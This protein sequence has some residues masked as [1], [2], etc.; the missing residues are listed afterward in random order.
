MTSAH[1]LEQW[2]DGPGAGEKGEPPELGRD[3]PGVRL[4]AIR[5]EDVVHAKERSAFASELE[6]GVIKH[7]NLTGGRP[8]HCAGELVRLEADLVALN[9][10]SGRYGP[11]SSEEMTA[12][13]KAF[14][15][16]GYGVWSYGYD[17]E[18]DFPFR[19]GSRLPEWVE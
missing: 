1:G 6:T 14:R 3:A 16:S 19:F 8:A 5:P 12:V 2:E 4:W 18:N 15:S 13:A 11:T 17:E 7:T 10:A 9:G